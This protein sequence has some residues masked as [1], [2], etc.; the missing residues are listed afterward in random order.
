MTVGTGT[1]ADPLLIWTPQGTLNITSGSGTLPIEVSTNIRLFY[2]LSFYAGGAVDLNVG[3]ATTAIH[4]TADMKGTTSGGTPQS[5]GNSRL[6]SV[7]ESSPQFAS[8]RAFVGLQLNLLPATQGNFVA[9]FTQVS[10]SSI[11][12]LAALVGVR[13]AW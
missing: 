12:G 9:L 10:A 6:D 13:G 2:F 11:G 1:P 4:L 7:I 8:A 3:K 5:A